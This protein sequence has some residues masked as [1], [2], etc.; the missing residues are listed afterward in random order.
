MRLTS[1]NRLGELNEE[2]EV[3]NAEAQPVGRTDWGECS[4]DFGGL[5]SMIGFS[6]KD[7]IIVR[8]LWDHAL[9]WLRAMLSRADGIQILVYPL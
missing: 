8:S 5:V 9:I 4:D 2:L 3:L 6:L 1:Q 7:R